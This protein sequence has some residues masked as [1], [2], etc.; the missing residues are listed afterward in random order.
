M[1]GVRAQQVGFG[2]LDR[3]R[4][5]AEERIGELEGLLAEAGESEGVREE[6]ISYLE[7]LVSDAEKHA[8]EL[9]AGARVIESDL[10]A[11]VEAERAEISKLEGN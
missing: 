7:A 9:E 4:T 2:E 10:R 5:Q 11:E 3:A 8:K 1:I 6:K